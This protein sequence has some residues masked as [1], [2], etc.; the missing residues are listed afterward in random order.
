MADSPRERFVE[1]LRLI[2]PDVEGLRAAAHMA[3]TDAISLQ[4]T[5]GEHEGRE[6]DA[7]AAID[8]LADYARRM[9]RERDDYKQAV[10]AWTE[11]AA[12]E[13]ME[14]DEA[15]AAGVAEGRRGMAREAAK[16]LHDEEAGPMAVLLWLESEAGEEK[17]G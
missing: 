14:R 4:A 16:R 17:H 15:R 10:T 13:R 1:A 12:K 11:Q 2:A 7:H 6:Q 3:L 5:G 9:E 8:A